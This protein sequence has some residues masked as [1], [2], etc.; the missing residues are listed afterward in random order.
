M[1]QYRFTPKRYG[2]GFMPVSGEGRLFT[3]F[4][5]AI[6]FAAMR[7]NGVFDR[8][9]IEPSRQQ[10]AGVVVDL[11]FVIFS[12]AWFMASKM[13]EPLKWRWGGDEDIT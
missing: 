12:S 1:A 13:K 4:L 3:L 7:R 6:V 9:I 11:F 10:I 5:L 8:E 2:R